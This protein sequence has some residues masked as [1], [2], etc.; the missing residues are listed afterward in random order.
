MNLIEIKEG[1]VSILIPNPKDYEKNGK[2]DPS[3]SPV[4]YNTKMRLNRDLS[5]L[6]LSVIKPKVVIDAL[7]ASGIRGIRY[8]VEVGNIEKLILNDKN[9][10]A[11]EL[12]NENIKR[13]NV[14]AQ[15][16]NRDAN[17]LLYEVKADYIDIDPFGS[18]SPFI[19]ASMYSVKNK[20]YVAFT[21]TDLS[22]LECASKFS[23][24]R[25][26]DLICEK[27]SFSKELGIRGLI[28]KI[29]REASILKKAA[30]PIFSFYH[31]YYYRVLFKVEKGAKK[32]DEL[33]KKQ[34]YYYECPNC[35]FREVDE[36]LEKKKCPKCKSDMRVYGPA[37]SGELWDKDFLVRVRDN[38]K[39]FEYLEN[40]SKIKKFLDIIYEE[41]KYK[42]PYYRID[43]ISSKTKSN[44]PKKEE[45]IKCL[46]DASPTHFDYRGIKSDKEFDEIVSC[47]KK[48]AN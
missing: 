42:T 9:P 43:F 16:T 13:N 27:L 35:G 41:S 26:Y 44:M 7:S 45:L 30:Y 37:W 31:D 2:F 4:F 24:R 48:S 36:N 25:K 1:K 15:V 11:V 12:I 6:L 10:I 46:G 18:P 34:K 32:A 38:L 17:S 3:W 47:I 20:G 29:I 39:N 8:Y 5:V 19:L 40:Y 22:A 33:L 23:A 14:I 21:A 28:A